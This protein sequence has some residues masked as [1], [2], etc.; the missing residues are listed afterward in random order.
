LNYDYPNG[1]AA[2]KVYGTGIVRD[3]VGATISLPK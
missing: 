2:R 3:P 1:G